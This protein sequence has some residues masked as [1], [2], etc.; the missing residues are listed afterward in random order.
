MT[1]TRGSAG[2]SARRL[3]AAVVGGAVATTTAGAFVAPAGATAAPGQDVL[4]DWGQSVDEV[5]QEVNVVVDADRAVTAARTRYLNA[6]SAYASAKHVQHVTYLA[7]KAALT[8][9]S[10]AM[11]VRRLA[12]YQR[13][14]TAVFTTAREVAT[15]Q[16]AMVRLVDAR[17]A[18]VRAQHYV[19]APAVAL[20]TA[21]AGLTA[22]GASGQVTLSWTAVP[23]A[24]GYHV[25]RDGVQVATTTA[26]GY[27]DTGLDNGTPYGYQVLATNLA[28]WSPLTGAVSGTPGVLAP[29]TP[30]GL[31][32]AP[33]DG[34][35][36]LAWNAVPGATSYQVFR[37]ATLVGSPATTTFT[38]SGLTDAVAY[39]Y[40]VKALNGTAA[41]GATAPV[42][43]TPV[44]TAP[45]A[46]TDVVATPGNATV[47]V[48]WMASAGA[49]SYT[50]LRNGVAVATQSGTTYTDNAVL[51]D[52]S[53]S[54]SVLAYR[55]N[56]P[57]S[58]PS[59]TASA[60]P[61]APPLASPSG[62]AAAPGD[63]TVALTWTSVVG[64]TGYDVYRGVA[65]VASVA[66]TSFTDTGLTNGTTYSYFVVATGSAPSSSPS[67]TVT[68]APAA[69]KPG[70]PTGLS[71]TA[72]DKT[73]ALTWVAVSGAT[74]YNVY[75]GTSKIGSSTSPSYLDSGLTNGTPY[76]YYVT[77][78]KAG[79]ES[80]GSST[81]TVTPFVLTPAVPT[82]LVATQGNTQVAISWSPAAN[83]TGYLVYRGA[84]L[85]STQT[86][87][88][89]TDIGLTN[90]TSYTWTVVATNGTARSAASAPLSATPLAPAPAAPTGL[91]ATA[92]N[93]QV[94]LGWTTV[95]TAT[96]YKVYRN[97]VYVAS[98][99]TT[100]FIDTGLTNGTLYTYYVTAV[101]AT[102]EGPASASATATPAKPP[103]NGT[104]TGAVTNIGSGSSVHGTLKV[105]ITVT[106][107]KITLS[108]GT[109]LTNDGS[110]TAK[111]NSTA[112]PQYDTKAVAANGTAFTK[113]SG[114]TLTYTA[115]KTSLQSAITAAGL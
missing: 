83:A 101:A 77:A 52:T 36:A 59:D 45:L 10:R 5:N 91:T 28:G 76:T 35:V 40:T 55:L 63:T 94:T 49:T 108:K 47:T 57:A 31:V 24:T 53:Y 46:P 105:V 99:A 69:A 42:A 50:V 29:P 12:S 82:G 3:V 13:A 68:A 33:G 43:C 90:G 80:Q 87:T 107:S 71:G 17:T 103:V 114:A 98:S 104:F 85:V 112:I 96:S 1:T 93:T 30:T 27:T 111:I 48:T 102:T 32:A 67:A 39:S 60:T 56:S 26:A 66:T 113:V 21:P 115:Y 62:L 106:N 6:L 109:L 110:E 8:G 25:L 78:I 51:N 61:A 16:L 75:R 89:F 18:A 86:G 72:G 74:S 79:V 84:T 15:S 23:G 73:A 92:G 2:A 34:T 37:G 65:K 95:T 100:S 41:S 54:Y 22:V 70:A 20:P 64:A 38:D 19:R 81:V 9:G 88:T 11:V 7:Y 44:A 58:A 14:N 97:G 4:N